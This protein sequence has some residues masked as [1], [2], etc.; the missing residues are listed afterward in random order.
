MKKK[1]LILAFLTGIIFTGCKKEEPAAVYSDT[2]AIGTWDL[3]EVKSGS[4][5]LTKLNNNLP[6]EQLIANANHT[7]SRSC[8]GTGTF[9][10][11]TISCSTIESSYSSPETGTWSSASETAFSFT[12]AGSTVQN[13]TIAKISATQVKFFSSTG[14]GDY[15]IFTKQ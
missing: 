6:I 3:T 11:L 4:N 7:Y 15:K 5:T 1:L 12:P 8:T 9:I 10:V 14:S 2:W 13:Y